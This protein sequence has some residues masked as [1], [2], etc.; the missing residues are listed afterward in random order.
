MRMFARYGVPVPEYYWDQVLALEKLLRI[1]FR[2][3]NID[4]RALA[5]ICYEILC[6]YG[7]YRRHAYRY[8]E[9][10]E[11]LTQGA[12]NLLKALADFEEHPYNI[13]EIRIISKKHNHYTVQDMKDERLQQKTIKDIRAQ[14]HPSVHNY[15]VTGLEVI[16]EVFNSIRTNKVHLKKI[17]HIEDDA[18][19]EENKRLKGTQPKVQFRQIC[20]KQIY[21]YLKEHAPA[22]TPDNEIFYWGGLLLDIVGLMPVYTTQP[23]DE[24]KQYSHYRTFLLSNFK[25]AYRR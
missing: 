21:N 3:D 23:K 2:I 12:N 20:S 15:K 16:A 14:R 1:Q 10:I 18:G 7:H 4:P 17:A 24:S 13:E 6:E 11:P 5:V 25:R 19:S 8:K 22:G 9:I